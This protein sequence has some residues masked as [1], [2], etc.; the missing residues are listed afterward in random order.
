MMDLLES[1]THELE[2]LLQS[3]QF[4]QI[5]EIFKTLKDPRVQHEVLA[6]LILPLMNQDRFDLIHGVNAPLPSSMPARYI[7]L[8]GAGV[9]EGIR[10][11]VQ[12]LDALMIEG[13]EKVV[14]CQRQNI[15][16]IPHF[17][18]PILLH[19]A[20]IDTAL[21]AKLDPKEEP[22][23]SEILPHVPDE[24]GW[25][26]VLSCNG[27]YF[28]RFAPGYLKSC[29]GLLDKVH[30]HFQMADP[31]PESLSIFESLRKEFKSSLSYA[32]DP[33]SLKPVQLICRRFQVAAALMEKYQKPLFVTDIDIALRPSAASLLKIDESLYDVALFEFPKRPAML[34]THCSLVLLRPNARVEKFLKLLSLYLQKKLSE[35]SRLWMLDQCAVFALSRMSARGALS[36]L[37]PLRWRDLH[38]LT[39]KNLDDFQIEQSID[40]QEKESLRKRAYS[41]FRGDRVLEL[42]EDVLRLRKRGFLEK[43]HTSP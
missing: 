39:E 43:C 25:V 20:G 37:E 33:V 38:E 32:L 15:P 14:E 31:T 23:A 17:A 28:D 35:E 13:L 19:A 21:M 7:S 36:D 8:F 41:G 26:F 2:K 5:A 42:S 3:S 27:L 18:Q 6:R 9:F 1:L 16:L 22:L 30:I 29:E 12:A 40:P 24:C 34:A 10:G 4:E 11:D